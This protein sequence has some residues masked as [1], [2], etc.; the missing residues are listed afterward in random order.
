M[1]WGLWF[2][3][4]FS[5]ILRLTLKVLEKESDFYIFYTVQSKHKVS[6]NRN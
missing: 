6:D 1:S 3:I 5:L 2:K 4:D